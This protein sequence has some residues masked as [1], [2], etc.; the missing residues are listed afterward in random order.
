MRVKYWI[1]EEKPKVIDFLD[2]YPAVYRLKSSLPGRMV[3]GQK[4]FGFLRQESAQDMLLLRNIETL[5]EIDK[6][7]NC[8]IFEKK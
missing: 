3:W 1:L 4:T 7:I 8:P 2:N 6:K 5:L